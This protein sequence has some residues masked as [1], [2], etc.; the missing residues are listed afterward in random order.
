VKSLSELETRR[1]ELLALCDAQRADLGLRLG[2]L[3]PRRWAQ[4]LAGGAAAGAVGA[5]R[6]QRRH[7]LAWVVAVAALL[8]LRRPREAL[9]LLA[10]ARGA[11][12]LAARA[13]EVMG[14]VAA[15]RRNKR[16]EERPREV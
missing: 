1:R 5:L 3:G 2:Q 9:S 6:S 4:A 7:P 15:M 14:V 10:R 12:T 13:A 16:S 11:L 8:L